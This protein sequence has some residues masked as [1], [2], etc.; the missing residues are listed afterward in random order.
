MPPTGFAELSTR[1]IFA[2]NFSSLPFIKTIFSQVLLQTPLKRRKFLIDLHFEA[3]SAFTPLVV[4]QEG[5]P[6]C[7]EQRGGVLA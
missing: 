7:K 3:F 1:E 4:L 6:A 2:H 5:H